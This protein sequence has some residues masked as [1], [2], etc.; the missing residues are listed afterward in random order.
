MI[1]VTFYGV[2]VR[3]ELKTLSIK[4]KLMNRNRKKYT[5]QQCETK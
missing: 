2:P 5:T 3:V 1:P 4:L